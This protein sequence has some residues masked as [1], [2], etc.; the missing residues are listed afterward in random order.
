MTQRKKEKKEL[1]PLS[2]ETQAVESLVEPMAIGEVLFQ[3][4]MFTDI[5][6]KAQA[7]VKILAGKEL[8]ISPL[9]SLSNIFMV[10]GKVSVMAKIVGSLIKKSEKYDYAIKDL[11]DEGC[12]LVFY[13]ISQDKKIELGTSTFNKQDAAKAGLIN[14][15]TYKSYPKNMYFARALSNGAKWFTP[16]V[17]CGYTEG[18]D[19]EVIK[20]EPETKTIT[21]DSKGEVSNGETKTSQLSK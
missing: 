2:P 4:G 7:V 19:F 21:M 5:K 13:S 20:S 9:E 10:N 12:T 11:T 14:R 6:S 1:V 3:S 8:G 18:D 15:E 17:Y 16:D